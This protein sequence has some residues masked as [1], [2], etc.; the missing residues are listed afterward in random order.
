MTE[1]LSNEPGW[2]SGEVRGHVGW[3]P[4]AY[5]EKMDQ[6]GWSDGNTSAVA[7]NVDPNIPG[8]KRHHLEGIQ[9]LPENVSDNG[10]IADAGLPSTTAPDV[11]NSAFMPVA[12][13]LPEDT[14]SPILGQVNSYID[15]IKAVR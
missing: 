9:E 3:F 10:S 1:S 6:S 2:L 15:V 8:S 14:S 5:V 11:S 7:G 4:E 13:K 12:G